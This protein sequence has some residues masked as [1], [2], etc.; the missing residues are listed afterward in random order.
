[1]T[2]S[3]IN[4]TSEAACKI[5]ELIKEEENNNLHLRVYVT[6]G[7]CSGFQYG[8]AFDDKINESE[9]M[10]FESTVAETDT[11]KIAAD[12]ISFI[13]LKGAFID[14]KEDIS[15]S[16]FIIKNPNAKVTCSCGSSFDVD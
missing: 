13:Y 12:P 5:L 10:I 11:I 3:Q 2:D 7:G 15:G 8:F 4:V 1:M 6:G 9:D 16:K 14:Y